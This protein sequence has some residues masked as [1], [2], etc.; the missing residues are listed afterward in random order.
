MQDIQ[1][2]GYGYAITSEGSQY[3]YYQGVTDAWNS[4]STGRQKRPSASGSTVY[5]WLRS[6]TYNNSGTFCGVSSSGGTTNSYHANGNGG[7]A[8]GF[9]I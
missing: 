2:G 8:P 6:P 1:V 5:W 9:S 3:K 7:V 4:S